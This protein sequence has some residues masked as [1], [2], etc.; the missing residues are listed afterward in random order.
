MKIL[1]ASS[2]DSDAI[3]HFEQNHDVI[4]AFGASEE[5]LKEK[6]VDREVLIFRSGV[7]ITADVMAAAPDLKLIMRGGSG[8]DNIDLDYV[9]NQEN[10][11]LLRVPGPGARAVA[12]MAFG[13][14]LALAR[15]I[16][17]ADQ[18]TRKGRWMKVEMMGWLLN[19]KT[20]GIIGAGNIGTQ[21][22]L[23]G[24]AWGMECIGCVDTVTDEKR[25]LM[26]HLGIRL[27]SM[28]EVLSKAD[29]MAVHVPLSPRTRDLIGAEELAKMKPS[30]FLVNLARGH[31]VNEEALLE[32][33][34]T[35]KLAGAAM[36]VHANE[37]EGKISP[38]AELDNVILT[39]HIGASAF[40][41]QREIG[42]IMVNAVEEYQPLTSGEE[43]IQ[44]I[45]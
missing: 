25:L 12:E 2:I 39:P 5:V 23:L 21:T 3:K 13:F 38:L 18:A 26:R 28:D 43:R 34:T 32:A 40:D 37:G 33:L 11:L 17:P 27:T 14:M 35:G 20:L 31:V 7:N 16:L 41:S 24:K 42:Q 22:G 44:V 29:F 9:K 6:I 36:D 19:G 1:I 10:I 8:I 4:C 30:A 15:N 45:Y